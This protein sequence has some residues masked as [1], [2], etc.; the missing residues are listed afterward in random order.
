MSNPDFTAPD[1]EVSDYEFAVGSVKGLRGW[2]M[3]DQGRLTGVTHRVVWTPG[4][5]VAQCR[6]LGGKYEPC[7]KQVE[8]EKERKANERGSSWLEPSIYFYGCDDPVCVPGK[9][10]FVAGTEAR[11]AFDADCECGFWAYDEENHRP[12]GVVTGIIEAYGKVTI[13][14]R[15]FRAEKARIVALTRERPI[16]EEGDLSLSKWLRLKALYPDVAFYDDHD[17]MLMTHPEVL[18]QWDP[19]DEGFWNVEPPAPR[20]TGGAVSIYNSALMRAIY[21]SASLS[22]FMPPTPNRWAIGGQA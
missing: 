11:H 9:G 12:H 7:P 17:D 14:T 18:K 4:E 8:A 6:D 16:D 13:G 20:P 10:H 5:N 22:S 3:D 15:G 2:D 1:H 19:V 21:G